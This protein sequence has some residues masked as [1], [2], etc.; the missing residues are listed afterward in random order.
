M[1]DEYPTAWVFEKS[2]ITEEAARG[3]MKVSTSLS[4][5]DWVLEQ[6]RH[7]GLHGATISEVPGIF[8]QRH[9]LALV[10]NSG[11]ITNGMLTILLEIGS[12]INRIGLETAQTFEQ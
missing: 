3:Y 10:A 1:Y 9:V 2:P 6:R 4:R 8:G 7:K 12:N 5:K 11:T